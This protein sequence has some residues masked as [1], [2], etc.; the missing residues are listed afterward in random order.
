MPESVVS[1]GVAPLKP[2]R[3]SASFSFSNRV[4]RFVWALCWSALARWT[5]EKFNPWRLFLLRL[6]GA[7]I[8]HGVD[9]SRSVRIWLPRHLRV[10]DSATLG[11]G[12]D[13]YNMAPVEIGSHTIISQR[14]VLCGGTHDTSDPDFQLVARPIRIGERAW[15]A[16][17]A[18]VGPGADVGDG[19]VLGAR[20]CAFGQLDAWTIYAGNPAKPIRPRRF[21]QQEDSSPKMA[22]VRLARN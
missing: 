16:A 22:A 6:F 4:E 21:R 18:F 12:V 13:C 7:E 15:I 9:I 5:P 19:A 2:A 14:A 11:P 8:G 1:R 3:G 17:E 10:S 20:G